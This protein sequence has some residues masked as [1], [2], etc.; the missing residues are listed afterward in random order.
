MKE[1]ISRTCLETIE[2]MHKMYFSQEFLKSKDTNDIMYE[3]LKE[4]T[5]TY[6]YSILSF[7]TA[8]K[9]MK[10][11]QDS[12]EIFENYSPQDKRKVKLFIKYMQKTC[13]LTHKIND[14]LAGITTL[15]RK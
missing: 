10:N 2:E 11:L 7:Y 12:T 1:S 4:S 6:I 8:L 15:I 14:N 3:I 9:I 5:E 13:T